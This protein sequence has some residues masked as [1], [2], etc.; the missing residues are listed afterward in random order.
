MYGLKSE[1]S[2]N[3]MHRTAMLFAGQ[4]HRQDIAGRDQSEGAVSKARRENEGWFE[5]IAPFS[6]IETSSVHGYICRE[7]INGTRAAFLQTSCF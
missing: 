6:S 2:G 4:D 7:Y 3:T 5:T 1:E